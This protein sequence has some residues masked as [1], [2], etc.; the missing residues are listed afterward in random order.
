MDKI[1]Y[2]IQAI[3]AMRDLI[4]NVCWKVIWTT[5]GGA[6]ITSFPEWVLDPIT[7]HRLLASFTNAGVTPTAWANLIFAIATFLKHVPAGH[8]NGVSFL[9]TSPV[10]VGHDDWEDQ[11]GANELKQR[12]RWMV[13]R[14]VFELD[15]DYDKWFNERC[16][17]KR[18]SAD[19]TM[20]NHSKAY[21]VD[22]QLLYVGS[23]NPY[24]NYNEEHGIWIDDKETINA[25]Y[26]KFWTPRW[27]TSAEVDMSPEAGK[28]HSIH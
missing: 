4:Q 17:F 27:N 19:G 8:D 15:A 24:P 13:G 12:I 9:L 2:P 16:H 23:D 6:F 20:Y 14:P 1:E 25:W 18:I 28:W 22:K 7:D 21:C 26:E 10:S 11:V 5:L 3:D